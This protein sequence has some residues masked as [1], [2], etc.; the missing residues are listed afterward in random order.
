MP[1]GRRVNSIGGWFSRKVPSPAKEHNPGRLAATSQPRWV[2]WCYACSQAE[3]ADGT[4]MIAASVVQVTR[5]RSQR[6]A[7]KWKAS[8]WV[9]ETGAAGPLLGRVAQTPGDSPRGVEKAVA[10]FEITE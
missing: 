3:N 2:W 8:S 7:K 4:T 5:K 1:R 9:W 10:V 6:S